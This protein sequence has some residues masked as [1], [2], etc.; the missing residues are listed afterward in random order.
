MARFRAMRSQCICMKSLTIRS[1]F[2]IINRVIT[3]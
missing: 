3:T 2:N 1:A